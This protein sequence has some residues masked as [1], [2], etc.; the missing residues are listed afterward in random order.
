[1]IVVVVVVAVSV[2]VA[3]DVEVAVGWNLQQFTRHG[4]RSDL[5]SE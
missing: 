4:G 5:R 3:D 2:A 1:M